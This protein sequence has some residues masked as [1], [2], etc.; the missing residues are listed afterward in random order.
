MRSIDDVDDDLVG[1]AALRDHLAARLRARQL[2]EHVGIPVER[3]HAASRDLRV[4]RRRFRRPGVDDDLDRGDAEAFEIEAAVDQHVD[5]RAAE[6]DYVE[7]HFDP[8][9][10]APFLGRGR[11]ATFVERNAYFEPFVDPARPINHAWNRVGPSTTLDE[12][13][14]FLT[15]QERVAILT[16]PI[17]IGK[18]K[19]AYD[20]TATPIPDRFTVFHL[21]GTPITPEAL[22]EL[23]FGPGLLVVDDAADV[24]GLA[25]L[26]AHALR[27]PELKL[28]LTG[29]S[30]TTFVRD[31]VVQAGF[32]RN[33]IRL[34]VQRPLM[35][36]PTIALAR[37]VL[38][39]EYPHMEEAIVR[40]AIDSPLDTILTA[41]FLRE[42]RHN[43]EDLK[44]NADVRDL[45]RTLYREIATGRVSDDVQKD[46]VKATL[47]LLA[48][49][50][51]AK[52]EDESW[53]ASA[54]ASVAMDVDNLLRVLDAL[55]DAGILVRRGFHYKVV[56]ELLRQSILLE[57]LVARGRP[58]AFPLRLL[59]H[60]PLD[61]QLLRN[62]AIADLESRA[63][64]GPDV[65][66]TVWHQARD[67][68]MHANSLVRTQFL[69]S[70]NELGFYKPDEVY[71]LVAYLVDHRATNE[72]TQPF[73]SAGFALGH[74]SVVR[75]IPGV[76]RY[77]ML[78]SPHLVARCVELLWHLGRDADTQR[79]GEDPLR[80]VS[81]L[82]EYEIGVGTGV[83][84]TI[85]EA[86]AALIDR[87]ERDTPK[88]SLLDLI[89][90]VLAR[91][92]FSML[93]RGTQLAIYR[94]VLGVESVRP[95]RDRAIS[96]VAA[97]ALGPDDRRADRAIELL[98]D[99]LRDPGNQMVA[100]TPDTVASWDRERAMA[101]ATFDRIV[102]DGAWPVRELR[103]IH[104]LRFY[105]QYG[106]T[107]LVLERAGTI[108]KRLAPTTER[109]RYRA[110]VDRFLVFDTFIDLRTED[111]ALG[112]E[113]RAAFLERTTEQLLQE[114]PEPDGLLR[115]LAMRLDVIERAGL[116]GT[117]WHIFWETVRLRPDLGDSLG[118]AILESG[119]PRFLQTI[120]PFV[121][122]RFERDPAAGN[123]F[124]NRV[125]NQGSVE[126]AI[127]VANALPLRLASDGRDGAARQDVFARLLS[128]PRLEVRRAAIH[129]LLFFKNRHADS[130]LTLVL[131]A[132]LDD[133]AA[134]ADRAFMAL[135]R[136]IERSEE[137]ILEALASK[138]VRV[139]ELEYWPLNFLTKIA[140]A[141]SSIVLSL[142]GTRIFDGPDDR[143][144]HA[145]PFVGRE[146]DQLIAALL[147]S[148]SFEQE[149][150]ALCHRKGVTY[151]ERDRLALLVGHVGKAAP[152]IVKRM[153]E[154]AL[155][156]SD[157]DEQQAGVSWLRYIPHEIVTADPDY[158]VRIIERAHGTSEDLGRR[159]EGQITNALISGAEA[160]GH[161]EPA[162]S[163]SRLIAIG[164]AVL[165][166]EGLS[167]VARRFFEGLQQMGR[168]N[169]ERSIRSAEEA[170][171]PQ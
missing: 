57:A 92:I 147:E 121:A 34:I 3:T 104:S 82:A 29:P 96:I 158:I 135:P 7:R 166:R 151:R 118:E 31:S 46:D 77:V 162:P 124:A 87:G 125:L 23:R 127:G 43:P 70:L 59:E 110:L 45:V 63:T 137:L 39:G 142:L 75:E 47:Q 155:D 170:F 10:V 88:H 67:F 79:S 20:L 69:E 160:V 109:D 164:E 11:A 83:A 80:L 14:A 38:E 1:L 19:A 37:Q 115:D 81:K 73:F 123:T 26:L 154:T 171:G 132:K 150:G 99:L 116:G 64:G 52:I 138:L 119:E 120:A 157:V 163:D 13:N 93:S 86:V 28:L 17:G 128:D 21:T 134:L 60:F 144:Y 165:Q 2:G 156:A 149:L 48:A 27:T 85:V 55:D 8:S 18:T 153:V 152:A 113:R 9:Y 108:L 143:S 159:A 146:F 54:A 130:I 148:S 105:A 145:V 56:P 68:V 74:D 98:V 15:S 141:H 97:S 133:D 112:E 33:E 32:A 100:P 5:L 40:Y 62:V 49:L 89:A 114:F 4:E 25:A 61:A 42:Q 101:F 102:V 78:G 106:R 136:D 91:D 12:L 66:T 129:N 95:L 35:R 41:R 126:A 36:E 58:T 107:P 161:Y 71:E 103:I 16:G 111:P 53:L 6:A 65:F 140:P 122:T 84:T 167:P 94:R 24:D 169:A 22:R 72:E 50:G 30:S 117:S 44:S 131:T 168:R 76:L 90:P 139:P 51:P